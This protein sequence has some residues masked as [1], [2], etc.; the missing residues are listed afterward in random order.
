[1]P[2]I[3]AAALKKANKKLKKIMEP[4]AYAAMI[5]DDDILRPSMADSI[6]AFDAAM[7]EQLCANLGMSAAEK[8]SM[9][10]EVDAKINQG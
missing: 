5:R 6:E 7:F 3:L 4:E 9:R 2:K 1:M 8:T 10:A